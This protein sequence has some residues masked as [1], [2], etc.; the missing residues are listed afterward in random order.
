MTHGVFRVPVPTNEPVRGYA[1]GSPER[2]SLVEKLEE[3]AD[4]V[5]EIPLIIGGEEVHTDDFDEVVMP[6]AHGHLLARVHKAGA[7]EVR[8]A[9]DAAE[10]ARHDWER[11]PWEER[12]AVMLRAADLWPARGAT[13]STPRRC[14]GSRRPRTRPRSTPRAS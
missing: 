10:A 11:L 12:A 9:I 5:I 6:H 13:S 2:R 4:E 14:S 8:R 3:M 7:A 1:S